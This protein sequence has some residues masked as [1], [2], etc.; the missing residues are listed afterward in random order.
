MEATPQRGAVFVLPTVA[1]G[2]QGPVAAWVST[3]GWAAAARR[4]LGESWIVT[5]AGVTTPD[6][7][8]RRGSDPALSPLPEQSWRRRVPTVVKT[9][10]K[11]VRQWRR[12]R[13]FHVD[14]TPWRD[15]GVQ[16]VWQRHELFAD[17]GITLARALGVPAVVFVPATHVW[18][19]AQWGVRR[20]GWGRVLERT[21][22]AAP[23]RR[24]D[25]V[26]CGT[27]VVAAEVRRLGVNADRIVVTPTGVDVDAFAGGDGRAA[28]REALGLEDRFV[29]GWVGSFRRFHALDQLVA[30][31][32]D[33]P[34]CALLMVGDGPERP[35]VEALARAHGVCA[36]FTGTVPHADMARHLAAMDAAVVVAERDSVFHYSPLKLAEYLAAGLAVVV[37]RVPQ[38]D[39]R[40]HDGV[41]ALVVA[42]G[43]A[44]ALRDALVALACDP[45]RRARLGAA[46]RAAA[47][48]NWSWD[49][50]IRLIVARLPGSG[51]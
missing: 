33:V 48:A 6:D 4:V 5:P 32:R 29:V 35:R 25:L 50:A 28:T 11:D 12:A 46:A 40:L 22:E 49:E 2:Q 18:E 34:G 42:P 7:A 17:A 44:S 31:A 38:L 27:D 43:D 39:A 37:P 16:F 47:R 14:A 19:A 45:G 41:D 1:A 24:A 23:L 10:L 21:A 9:A 51:P 8:R 13:R 20:P 3:A 36:V 26:A 30:A 15:R